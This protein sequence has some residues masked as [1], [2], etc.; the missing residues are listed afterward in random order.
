MNFDKLFSE[1]IDGLQDE[2]TVEIASD[3]KGKL[4][5]N[6]AQA[7]ATAINKFFIEHEVKGS[8]G[9]ILQVSDP[10]G[11]I[12][13]MAIDSDHIVIGLTD[14]QHRFLRADLVYGLRAIGLKFKE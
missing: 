5:S 13:T 7:S 8:D 12:K 4:E 10:A 9:Q 1:W 11:M 3:M 2:V 14:G 6:E